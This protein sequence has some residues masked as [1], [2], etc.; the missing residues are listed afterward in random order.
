M[1]LIWNG[2]EVDETG[3][4]GGVTDVLA[5]ESGVEESETGGRGDLGQECES[6]VDHAQSDGD[7]ARAALIGSLT[8]VERCGEVWEDLQKALFILLPSG[9]RCCERMT[10]L[11]LVLIQVVTETPWVG[12]GQGGTR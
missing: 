8:R 6:K 2:V 5:K 1:E 3:A 11:K 10:P 4:E 7:S 9:T 12:R